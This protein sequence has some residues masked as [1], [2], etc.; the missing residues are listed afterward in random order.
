MSVPAAV[1][2]A[3]RARAQGGCEYC[4]S[5]EWVCA[6]RFTLD[7][8]LLWS[9]GETDAPDN[10]ALACRRCHERRDTFTT[11][12]DPVTQQEVP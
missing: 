2:L 7:H 5:P 9:R 8:L 10:L 12:R 3:V 1:H 6:A 11:G 4:H